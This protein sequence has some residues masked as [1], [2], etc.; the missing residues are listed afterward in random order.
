MADHYPGYPSLRRVAMTD[1]GLATIQSVT[2]TSDGFLTGYAEFRD[3]DTGE[4]LDFHS[5]FFGYTRDFK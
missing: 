1:R 2:E 3:P 4:L 5:V